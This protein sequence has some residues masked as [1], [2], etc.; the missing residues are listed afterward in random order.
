[1]FLPGSFVQYRLQLAG[2]NVKGN[3]FEQ[4]SVGLCLAHFAD[5]NPRCPLLQYPFV[6]KF[7]HRRRPGLERENWVPSRVVL[8][9]SLQVTSHYPLA[10]TAL[11]GVCFYVFCLNVACFMFF[12]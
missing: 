6:Y 5:L 1:M 4:M 2:L 11:C 8:A 7:I 12:Q 10:G 9:S 3:N